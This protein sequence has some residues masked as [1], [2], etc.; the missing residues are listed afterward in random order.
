MSARPRRPLAVVVGAGTMGMAIARRLGDT[1]RLLL[2]DRDSEALGRH[3]KALLDEGCEATGI[4]CD[5]LDPA[6][7][8]SLADTAS[9]AEGFRTLVH[10]VGLSPTMADAET[11]LRVNLAGPTRVAD[12]FAELLGPGTVAVFIASM[13]GHL[14]NP[15]PALRAALQDASK[16]DFVASVVAALGTELTPEK[17]YR[18]SKWALIRMCRRRAAAL[19]TRGAR[20]V[21]VSP[22]LITTPQGAREHDVQPLKRAM[23]ERI[24]LGREGTLIEIADAVDFL[25]SERASYISG[26]DLLVDGG[27]T[28]VSTVY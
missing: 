28:S 9:R 15:E 17:A 5:V 2:A 12:A 21:S 19:G 20:I 13:A 16:D 1:H 3:V 14:E 7:V 27:I 4:E 6:A 18:L 10:V 24:P 8:A 11:I 23:L 26:T 25:V 22:G